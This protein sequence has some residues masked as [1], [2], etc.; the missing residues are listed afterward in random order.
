MER[1][2][3]MAH[4]KEGVDP[5]SGSTAQSAG[6]RVTRKMFLAGTLGL[7]AGVPALLARLSAPASAATS[8]QAE[9]NTEAIVAAKY[10][11]FAEQAKAEGYPQVARLFRALVIAECFHA[12]W[13]LR[14]MG[15]VKGTADNL[16]AGADYEAYLAAKV[17]SAAAS[18][19][20]QEKEV[21]AEVLFNYLRG[22]CEVHEKTLR[23]AT[24]GVRAGKDMESLPIRICPRCG[25]VLVG[26]GPGTCP[27]CGTKGAEF[28]QVT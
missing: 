5:S 22:A 11:A 17:L 24:E 16:K 1:R 3:T 18:E 21:K 9:F 27:V 2:N 23:Q 6:V 13:L 26:A 4:D 19:A 20:R 15:G 10:A 28:I 25:A 12:E 8:I 14:L 7:S